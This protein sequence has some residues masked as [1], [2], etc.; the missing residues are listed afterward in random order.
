MTPE[1]GMPEENLTIALDSFGKLS[2]A[3]RSAIERR[4]SAED[5][6]QLRMLVTASERAERAEA[7]QRAIARKISLAPYS[8][9]LARRVARIVDGKLS[10]RVTPTARDALRRILLSRAS[11]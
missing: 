2:R 5:R 4:L 1:G 10:D 6:Q 3:D 7:R 9:W 11:P 8:V